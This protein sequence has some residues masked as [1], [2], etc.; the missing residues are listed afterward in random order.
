MFS[1]VRRTTSMCEGIV[2]TR[3]PMA[4]KQKSQCRCSGSWKGGLRTSYYARVMSK[5]SRKMMQ[6]SQ[7]T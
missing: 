6:L 3:L 1:Q 5:E 2:G 4:Y 7:G